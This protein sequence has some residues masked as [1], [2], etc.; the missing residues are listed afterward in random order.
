MKYFESIQL[1]NGKECI[2]RNGEASDASAFLDCFLKCLTETEYLTTYPDEFESD[3]NIVS[4]RLDAMSK[5]ENSIELLAI[6]DDTVVGRANIRCINSKDKL[7]HRAGFGISIIKEYWGMGIGSLLTKACIECAK[8]AG[9][10]QLELEAVSENE[11]ALRLYKK[12]GFIEYGRNPKAF[13]TREGKWQEL[14][15]M[16]LEL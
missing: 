1:A 11:S 10:A 9:F 5:G 8:K 2:L 6:V 4:G 12:H 13:K 14:V 15:L 3:L 16:R 7:K